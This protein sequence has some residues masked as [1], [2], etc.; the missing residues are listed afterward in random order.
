MYNNLTFATPAYYD[1]SLLKSLLSKH[2]EYL[3][4]NVGH[5]IIQLTASPHKA[6]YNN[7]VNGAYDFSN[8]N[9]EVLDSPTLD[10][11]EIT[12]AAWILPGSFSDDARLIS[13]ETGTS[14]PYSIYSLLLSVFI[15]TMDLKNWWL[16]KN[17]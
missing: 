1:A 10:V 14:N 13:K 9:L 4:K 2:N 11:D 7:A 16:I 12:I 8:S 17:G 3:A 15:C 5:N 6:F